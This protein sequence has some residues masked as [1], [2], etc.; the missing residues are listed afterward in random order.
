MN[1]EYPGLFFHNNKLS[2]TP[3]GERFDEW[4]GCDFSDKYIFIKN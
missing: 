2:I 4:E 3:S 1:L